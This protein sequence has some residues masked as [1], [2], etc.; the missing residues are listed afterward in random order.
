MAPA[1]FWTDSI[2]S[3][4]NVSRQDRTDKNAGS[5]PNYVDLITGFVVI[6]ACGWVD[7]IDDEGDGEDE[8]EE[9]G[10]VLVFTASSYCLRSRQP[11]AFQLHPGAY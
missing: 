2:V 6:L 9:A 11:N 5:S 7:G 8:E 3:A 10:E 4:E 1:G